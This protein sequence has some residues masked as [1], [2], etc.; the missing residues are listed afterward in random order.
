MSG[1]APFSVELEGTQF[2]AGGTLRGNAV[3]DSMIEELEGAGGVRLEV[4]MKV[5]GS[6]NP[7]TTKIFDQTIYTG[8][9]H[10]PL[11]CPFEVP[12]P[13]NGPCTF[14]GRHVKITWHARVTV[15][16]A[17]AFDPKAT[18]GFAVVP[19]SVTS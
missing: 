17:W 5:L 9:V 8:A 18:I 13:A 6:G 10:A 14:D 3:F 12:L 1:G 4:T 2:E 15:D 7:E 19:R 16:V 11:R